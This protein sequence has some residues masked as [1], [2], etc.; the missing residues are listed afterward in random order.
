M[1]LKLARLPGGVPR[2]VVVLH[3]YAY[4][5]G[6]VGAVAGHGHLVAEAAVA[7]PDRGTRRG[8]RV[9]AAGEILIE[10]PDLQGNAR[11]RH[12]PGRPARPGG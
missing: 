4:G 1:N 3:P 5:F 11:A 7:Q 12:S 8:G 2:A 10:Q 6:D 9:Q